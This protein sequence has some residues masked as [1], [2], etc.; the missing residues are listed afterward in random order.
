MG[1]IQL[2][3]YPSKVTHHCQYGGVYTCDVNLDDASVVVLKDYSFIVTI[4]FDDDFENSQM[5]S[6]TWSEE[7]PEN[8]EA[9][10]KEIAERIN[11][12]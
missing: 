6:I 1:N 12:L 5:H 11:H 4:E 10:E 2:E 9:I 8:Y 7:T 3:P